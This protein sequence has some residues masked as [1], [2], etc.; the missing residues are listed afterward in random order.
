[1]KNSGCYPLRLKTE[2][3]NALQDL[4]NSSYPTK[5]EFNN[6]FIIHS[7][8]FPIILK[9]VLPVCLLFFCLPKITQPHPQVSLV[10]GSRTFCGLPFW[11][12]FEIIGSIWQNF[13]SHWFNMTK[14]LKS[15]VQYD[16]ALSKIWSTAASYS[17]LSF[18]AVF[19]SL[20][21]ADSPPR[22]LQITAYK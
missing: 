6:C 9:G 12:H 11:R 14:L 20:P 4:Q 19:S 1:M 17:E 21:L 3:D 2:V 10:N 5:A 18:D 7:K 22:D 8:Y 13:W 15:L 16:K